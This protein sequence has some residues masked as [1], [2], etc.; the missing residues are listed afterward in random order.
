MECIFKRE[1]LFTGTDFFEGEELNPGHTLVKWP[2][3]KQHH[4]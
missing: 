4:P 3:T 1:T 2:P